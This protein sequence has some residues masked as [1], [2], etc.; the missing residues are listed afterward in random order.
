MPEIRD[1]KKV[2]E[3]LCGIQYTIKMSKN[4]KSVPKGYF[5]YVVPPL[6]GFWWLDNSKDFSV[7]NKS[8]LKTI[9]RVPVKGK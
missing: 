4:G 1:Y 8:K 2:I 5:D 6:E 3:V 7:E 9:L